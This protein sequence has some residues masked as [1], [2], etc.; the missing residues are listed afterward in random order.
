MVVAAVGARRG[1]DRCGGR[2]TGDSD[3]VAWRAGAKE[4]GNGDYVCG[5]GGTCAAATCLMVF[6]GLW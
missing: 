2:S 5:G 4:D 1:G 3:T 6:G